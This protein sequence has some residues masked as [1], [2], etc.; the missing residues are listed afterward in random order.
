MTYLR[1][2]APA[3][4]LIAI[5]AVLLALALLPVLRMLLLSL[6]DPGYRAVL[7]DAR[8]AA[9][10]VKSVRLAALA[11]A[12]ALAWGW[13]AARA[14]AGTRGT[15]SAAIEVSTYLPLFLPSIVLVKG[16]DYF[17]LPGGPARAL[18][19]EID[20]G[21]EA[22]AAA[23]LS[24]CYYPWAAIVLTAGLRG[25]DPAWRAVA[26]LHRGR[27]ATFLRV[28]LPLLAPYAA[29][30]ALLVF[31][32]ALSDCAVPSA[33]RVNVYPVEVVTQ[34]S[35]YYDM[36][37]AVACAMPPVVLAAGLSAVFLLAARV[38]R[39]VGRPHQA[40][41]QPAS[42]FWPLGAGALVAVSSVLPLWMLVST[43]GSAGSFSRALHVAGREALTSLWVSTL[44]TALLLFFG[45][46]M[47][48]ALSKTS[49]GLAAAAMV[50]LISTLAIPGAVIGLGVVLLDPAAY[51]PGS[52]GRASPLLWAILARSLAFPSLVLFAAFSSLEPGPLAA[53]AISG[54]SRMRIGA[55]IA[56][57]LL[58]PGFLAAAVLSFTTSLGELP[59]SMLAAPPG[60][61]TL[62]ARIHSLLY[63]AEDRLVASLCLTLAFFAMAAL[64]AGL[65]LTPGLAACGKS[66]SGCARLFRPISSLLGRG[67]A[68][69]RLAPSRLDLGRNSSRSPAKHFFHRLLAG[70]RLH[71]R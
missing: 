31:V 61:M 8:P 24:L 57:P 49:R 46:A 37:R 14:I 34:L 16:L 30:A 12:L 19:I 63:F 40:A 45:A 44:A 22:G 35:F 38:H 60:L 56:L 17:F 67:V 20:L 9:L 59:A 68:G 39:T 27:W 2:K 66:H 26:R 25:L 54:R 21:N 62:P 52:A 41:A 7:A 33:L 36:P 65:L 71:A 48:W 23:V 6:G 32:F 3:A 29:F 5:P 50:L 28:D 64:G 13:I 55:T 51:I 1:G 10:L 11:S 42:A 18:G 53:A 58:A 70:F 15:V 43:A 4:L 47:G 69:L